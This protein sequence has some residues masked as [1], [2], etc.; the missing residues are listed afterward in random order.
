ML[1]VATNLIGRDVG[2]GEGVSAGGATVG[3]AIA[4]AMVLGTDEAVALGLLGVPVQPANPMT[5]AAASSR[6]H[7]VPLPVFLM[8]IPLS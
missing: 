7:T 6:R 3:L 1:P 8:P 2:L 5:T 4:D